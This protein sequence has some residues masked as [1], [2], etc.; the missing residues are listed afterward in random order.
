MKQILDRAGMITMPLIPFIFVGL[1]L[2]ENSL[3][4]GACYA[5]Y[6]VLEVAYVYFLKS[7]KRVKEIRMMGFGF[8]IFIAANIVG[9]GI[10]TLLMAEWMQPYALWQLGSGP[11]AFIA[12]LFIY[13]FA[14]W[15]QHWLSHK[16][17]LLWSIHS[18]HHAPEQMNMLV[19]VN[20]SVL[21]IPYEAMMIGGVAGLLG[22]DPL[23]FVAAM[24]V[25][26]AWGTFL[27]VNDKA[28]PKEYPLLHHVLMT[29]IHHRVHHGKNV[30]Y[31]D[32]NYAIVFRI[33]DRV[34]GTFQPLEETDPLEYG[35]TRDVN[36]NSYF[37][38]HCG[39]F[40]LLWRDMR[41]APSIGAALAYL[42]MAP[43]WQPG[44]SEH[45]L[46]TAGARRARLL[47]GEQASN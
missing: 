5:A 45:E 9:F 26:G 41:N 36:T 11:V 16:V 27:H 8:A 33:W 25:A 7:V 18:P 32:T 46:E 3:L 10:T 13:D 6:L 24:G 39:E 1:A 35:I 20:L 19:G 2:N 23:T 14:Y 17:R 15:L 37:D 21:S 31:M 44:V 42:F 4:F 29:P 43:G 12:C 47:A 38:T 34:F 22:A 28:V 40:R 30:R